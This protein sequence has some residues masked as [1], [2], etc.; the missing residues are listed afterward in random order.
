MFVFFCAKHILDWRV[1]H[2]VETNQHEKKSHNTR[3][4]PSS[5]YLRD[6]REHYNHSPPPNAIAGK[7]HSVQFGF[8]SAPAGAN[9]AIP[10]VSFAALAP[11]SHV[12]ILTDV[13]LEHQRVKLCNGQ[14][15]A[16]P[17]TAHTHT[18][19]SQKDCPI[20]LHILCGSKQIDQTVRAEG[21]GIFDSEHLPKNFDPI[22]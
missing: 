15:A 7:R 12:F 14:R 21:G 17:K 13:K 19:A 8:T 18:R 2:Y 10:P 5:F 20:R 3:S 16:A 11:R 9:R 1:Y 6:A 4:F 22:R